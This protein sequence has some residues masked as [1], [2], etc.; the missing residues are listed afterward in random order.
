[1]ATVEWTPIRE[2]SLLT[3]LEQAQQQMDSDVAHTWQSIRL[4]QPELWQ[5]HPWADEGCG[6]WV[7]AVFGRTCIYYNDISGGFCQS[8]FKDWGYIDRFTRDDP[9]LEDLIGLSFLPQPA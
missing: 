1:M 2:S 8:Q 3:L 6:F 9:R 5:Q 7:V 4:P